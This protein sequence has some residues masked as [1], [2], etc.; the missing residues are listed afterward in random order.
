GLFH[1][2][3]RVVS[4]LARNSN[5]DRNDSLVAALRGLKKLLTAC[6]TDFLSQVANG[7]LDKSGGFNQQQQREERLKAQ[8]ILPSPDWRPLIEQAETHPYFLGDIEFLL[9][10]CGLFDRWL[11]A[12]RCDWSDDE[13]DVLRQSFTA[14]YD[15]ACAIFPRDI[16][17]WPAR[18][19]D[20]LWERAL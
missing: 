20:F 14:W 2:W 13:D 8:L 3:I 18:F 19:P 10:F 6:G 16:R 5:I 4:N 9:R 1:D 12:E 15:K 11:V 17:L 7:M